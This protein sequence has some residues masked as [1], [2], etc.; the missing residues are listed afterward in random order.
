MLAAHFRLAMRTVAFATLE[1]FL[2]E[3][4]R[5]SLRQVVLAWQ[6]EWWQAPGSG[7]EGRPVDYRRIRV[8]WVLGYDRADGALLRLELRDAEADR[9]QIETR[10]R[11]AGLEVELRQRRDAGCPAR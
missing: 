11:A 6:E 7:E 9:M 4:G 2:A 5:R 10:L 1:P 3:A 8:A